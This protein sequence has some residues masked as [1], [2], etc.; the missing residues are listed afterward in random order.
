M[1]LLDLVLLAASSVAPNCLTYHSI[2]ENIQHDSAL[3]NR[4]I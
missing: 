1:T 3:D 4:V 2:L